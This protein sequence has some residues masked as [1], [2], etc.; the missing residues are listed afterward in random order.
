MK[1][2]QLRLLLPVAAIVVV[3]GAAHLLASHPASVAPAVWPQAAA[4]TPTPSPTDGVAIGIPPAPGPS[5]A[6]QIPLLPGALQQLNGDTRDVA[7][8]V[9]GLLGQL[10]EALRVRLEQLAH[11]LEPGR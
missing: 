10:E 3:W 2:A 7:T 1:L 4:T 5:A 6:G 8:G 11:Q 9:Y